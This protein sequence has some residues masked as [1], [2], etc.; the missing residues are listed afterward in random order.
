VTTLHDSGLLR[1]LVAAGR[2]LVV[3]DYSVIFSVDA[4][5]DEGSGSGVPVISASGAGARAPFL[6]VFG[7]GMCFAL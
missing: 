7:D 5:E 2:W 3:A 1:A 4:N 6:F